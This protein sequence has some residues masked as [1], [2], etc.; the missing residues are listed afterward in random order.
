MKKKIW[1]VL[2]FILYLFIAGM[3]VLLGAL[4]FFI[5]EAGDAYN[6]EWESE[7]NKREIYEAGVPSNGNGKIRVGH[8]GRSVVHHGDSTIEV[9]DHYYVYNYKKTDSLYIYHYIDSLAFDPGVNTHKHEFYLYRIGMP[10]VL[11]DSIIK[12]EGDRFLYINNYWTI[13]Y[14][15]CFDQENGMHELYTYRVNH[16]KGI[17]ECSE[18]G[19]YFVYDEINRRFVPADTK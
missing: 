11:N 10:P 3:F 5:Y 12:E 13:E 8:R 7:E 14:K 15:K 2:R 19:C 9:V 6:G 18:D 16:V 17:P 4:C 1:R